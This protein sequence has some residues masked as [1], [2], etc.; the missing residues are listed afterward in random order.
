MLC[1]SLADT[2]FTLEPK[3]KVTK[4]KYV[5]NDK[6]LRWRIIYAPPLGSLDVLLVSR[7]LLVAP[8]AGDRP[9]SPARV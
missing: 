9:L 2:I 1:F 4:S 5:S 3:P 7:L 8:E 6:E